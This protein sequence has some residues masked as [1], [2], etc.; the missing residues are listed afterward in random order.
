VGG[1]ALSVQRGGGAVLAIAHVRVLNNN[2]D[3]VTVNADD[4]RWCH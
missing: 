4:S 1:V 3:A 2:D